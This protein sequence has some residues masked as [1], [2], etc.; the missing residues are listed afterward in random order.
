[1]T[2]R[3]TQ[4]P[5]YSLRGRL[6]LWLLAPLVLIGVLA[7]VDGY[8][9]A[10]LTADE[11]S[12]RVLAG[13]A[14]A[15]AE[16]V[17][18]NDEGKLE[19]DIPYVALQMLT[20]SE[21]DRVF[22]RIETGDGEFVTGYRK[23]ELPAPIA[24]STDQMRFSNGEFRGDPIRIATY[25]GATS[26]ST[27]SLGFRV[28]I[29]ETTNARNAIARDLLLRSAIRQAALIFTAILV[30]WFAI[31][32]ALRPLDKLESAVA[33]RSPEDL[34]PIRHRVP[35]EVD[36][37]VT[38]INDLVLR[39]GSA[40]Q[41]LRRFTSNASHQF[42]TP[43]ALI[44][45]HLEIAGRSNDPRNKAEAIANA[46]NAVDDAERLMSQMLILA[47]LDATSKQELAT[48]SSNLTNIARGVCE[49]FVLQLSNDR[50]TNIDLGF[51]ADEDVWVLAEKTLLQEVVRNLVDN[52]VKHAGPD[53]QIDV[54]VYPT[55]DRGL[56][57][58]QDNGQGFSGA[59]ITEKGSAPLSDRDATSN[60]SG[61]GL[62]IV[63]EILNLLSGTIQFSK[64]TPGGG[65]LVSVS[66]AG[67]PDPSSTTPPL[68]LSADPVS[69][70]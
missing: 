2:A 28:A 63:N 29:A 58:V 23:L 21:D 34:R 4:A 25:S 51:H 42:R 50:T 41:A 18:V 20:S 64:A 12:D 31:K 65:T 43:L 62:T 45:T 48:Q 26:S 46:K 27:K 13:S 59:T 54:S 22:Y 56:L 57:T 7:L 1:M 11:V 38:T 5:H 47:R 61:I 9:S 24:T 52:A 55:A 15:I 33:R 14:L 16:R 32:R 8:R 53:V 68:P 36:G 66:L 37:L 10:R 60:G 39:F 17:F 19:A 30:V 49:D 40:I 69:A 6:L 35:S 67:A 44:K 3:S 70:G